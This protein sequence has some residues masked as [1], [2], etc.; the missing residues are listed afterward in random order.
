MLFE[1]TEKLALEA[2]RLSLQT[3]TYLRL[4]SSNFF[5]G[6]L[7]PHPPVIAHVT[8]ASLSPCS[9]ATVALGSE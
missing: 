1:L 5:P 7:L 3:Q 8:R 4:V 2:S 6:L 9:Q